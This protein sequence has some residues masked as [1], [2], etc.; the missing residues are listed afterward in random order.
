[1]AVYILY[2]IEGSD[3]AKLE[4]GTFKSLGAGF[5]AG[6]DAVDVDNVHAYAL[7]LKRSSGSTL[8]RVARFG[9][10]RLQAAR[11]AQGDARVVELVIS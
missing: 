8:Q 9:F 4:V 2:R 7:Y 5:S 3:L 1:V 10:S 6:Q 11:G